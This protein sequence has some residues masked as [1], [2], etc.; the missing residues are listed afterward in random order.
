MD[1]AKRGAHPRV[2][3]Y[4]RDTAIQI[5]ETENDVI[6]HR[7]HLTG[8]PREAR[9]AGAALDRARAVPIDV[10]PIFSFDERVR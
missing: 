8:C 3:L 6:E 4:E 5:A 10:D 1:S 9:L 2:L 7:R